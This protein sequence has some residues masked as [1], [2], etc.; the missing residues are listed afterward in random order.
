MKLSHKLAAIAAAIT[1]AG[2][3]SL[4]MPAVTEA[5]AAAATP[6]NIISVGDASQLAKYG[7]G[8]KSEN[9]QMS[10]SGVLKTKVDAPVFNITDSITPTN[11]VAQKGGNFEISG[12]F[13]F[14]G[15]DFYR[16]GDNQFLP[17]KMVTLVKRGV[18]HVNYNKHYGIQIWTALHNPVLNKNGSAKKL[19]G[20]TN[21]NVYG[22]ADIGGKL[23]YNLGG[24]QFISGDYVTFKK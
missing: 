15:M 9:Y 16:V 22:A 18:A 7:K 2:T 12:I 4:A 8:K 5:H 24:D 1:M 6:V 10:F 19:K 20:Q 21:W 14:K 13:N 23:F 3:F 17:G 11:Q